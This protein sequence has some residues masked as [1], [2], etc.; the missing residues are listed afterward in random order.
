MMIT[1]CPN[2][3]TAF[4]VTPEQIK[5]MQ[6]KVRCGR[7]QQVFNAIDTLRDMLAEPALA[8]ESFKDLP[9]PELPLEEPSII[10]TPDKGIA[11]EPSA[12]LEPPIDPMADIAWQQ[13]QIEPLLHEQRNTGQ[14]RHTWAWALAAG[15]ALLLLLLQLIVHFRVELAV[16]LPDAKPLLQALCEP[17]DCDLPLPRKADLIGIESSDLH[18]DPGNRDRLILA[19]MLKNRAPFAQTYPHLELTLTDTADQPILRKV[20]APADYLP[21]GIDAAS[22]FAASGE[23]AVNLA[24]MHDHAANSAASGYRLYLFYP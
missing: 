17:M 20:L 23:L 22:G 8:S 24:L 2:C 1:R 15:L 14:R 3:A 9:E 18:P 12:L 4:R 19:A 13:P 16:L 5:A 6:G 10:D 21:K 7:C 11:A